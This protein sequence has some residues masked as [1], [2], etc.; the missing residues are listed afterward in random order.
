MW[1]L[2]MRKHLHAALALL[3]LG[4]VLANANIATAAEWHW[5]AP[6]TWFSDQNP[7][8]S[9][10]VQ[11]AK[12]ASVETAPTKQTPAQPKVAPVTANAT[13]QIAVAPAIT[14]VQLPPEPSKAGP[15]KPEAT[16]KQ[17]AAQPQPA[18]VAAKVATVAKVSP[19][20]ARGSSVINI[21]HKPAIHPFGTTYMEV[22]K[23]EVRLHVFKDCFG[24][25]GEALEK[26]MSATAVPGVSRPL[27]DGEIF[28]KQM[29]GPDPRN[30][31]E[32]CKV[33]PNIKV[34]FGNHGY[35]R[36]AERYVIHLSNGWT[37]ELTHPFGCHNWS[38]TMI[39]P[40][41]PAPKTPCYRVYTRYSANHHVVTHAARAEQS[42]DQSFLQPEAQYAFVLV[43]ID[44]T[45]DERAEL[46]ADQ[47]FGVGDDTG[48]HHERLQCVELC[49]NGAYPPPAMIDA[50]A[51]EKG[52][53]L[54]RDMPSGA[55]SVPCKDGE[56]YISVPMKYAARYQLW[57]V[58]VEKYYVTL[59][60]FKGWTS[61]MMFDQVQREE[62]E[63]SIRLKSLV[64]GDYVLTDEHR[65][66][67]ELKG[68]S[69]Y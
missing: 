62:V 46:V 11:I 49:A 13:A 51:R 21:W 35:N 41:P 39:P 44:V 1:R 68:E 36:E 58:E 10:K 18:P 5:F 2:P 37:M 54:P 25:T 9:V 6:G 40:V 32:R 59:S 48:F 56:C 47:C 65:V 63:A 22:T 50:L 55:F 69:H 67:R 57:C 31:T 42:P 4:G 43:H 33:V 3:A 64:D 16:P 12:P 8:Q 34:E 14:I 17:V 28:Q 60:Q 20:P 19:A 38:L 26:A 15:A 53:R 45:E 66:V 61:G 23:E 24:L 52:I 27:V 7:K 30:K 29:Y